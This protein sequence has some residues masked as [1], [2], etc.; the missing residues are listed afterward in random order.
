MTLAPCNTAKTALLSSV[1][2]IVSP[3]DR[4]VFVTVLNGVFPSNITCTATVLSL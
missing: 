4:Y 3:L 1:F 2:T